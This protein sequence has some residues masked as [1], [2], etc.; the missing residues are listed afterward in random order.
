MLEQSAFKSLWLP[1]SKQN[2]KHIT[3][4]TAQLFKNKLQLVKT[5]NIFEKINLRIL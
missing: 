1:V 4:F 2:Y 3:N 5:R